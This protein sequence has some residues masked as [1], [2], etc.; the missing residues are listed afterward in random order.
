MFAN[1]ICYRFSTVLIEFSILNKV[2]SLGEL[3]LINLLPHEKGFVVSREFKITRVISIVLYSNLFFHFLEIIR[4][5]KIF[6]NSPN[7][8][9]VIFKMVKFFF[10]IFQIVK[11]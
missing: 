8:K 11:F 1:T 6:N 2:F 7:C 5:P 10:F 4:T 9:K 3:K